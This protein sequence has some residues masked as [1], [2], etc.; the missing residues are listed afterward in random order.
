MKSRETGSLFGKTIGGTRI[1]P[2]AFKIIVVF[3]LFIL[4]SNLTSNYVNLVFNRTKMVN[5]M[6]QLLAKDL[7]DIYVY[8]N[9]QFEIYNYNKD[10]KGSLSSIEN[11]ALNEFSKRKS[12]LLGV[13]PDGTILFQA[14]H[15]ARSEKFEDKGTLAELDRALAKNTGEG[16]IQFN[17]NGE[18]YFGIYKHNPKWEVFIIRAEEQNEFYEESR[19]VF[20]DVSV[21]ILVIT[22]ICGVAGVYVLR[23]VLRFIGII[24]SEI[25][26]M[27]DEQQLR[28]INLK[29]APNDDITFLGVA[30][31]SLASTISNLLNIF[32]KFANRDVVIKAY[33]EREVRLEGRQSE[34]VILFSDIKS[35]T[36]ITETLGADI[37]KLLNLHYDQA[38]R[39]V[40][41]RDGIIGS[42]I[43][44]ALLAV[45]GA[46]DQYEG[47]HKNKSYQSVIT[48]YLLQDLAKKLRADM[49]AKK[50]DIEKNKGSLNEDQERVYQAVLLEIGVGIDGGLVFY[51]NIGSHIRMTNTVIGDNVN[52]ASRLEG[53][54]REYKLP[55]ICSEYIKEDIEESEHAGEIKFF[56]IDVVKVKGKTE[57]K[58]IYWPV[59]KKDY[60]KALEKSMKAFSAGLELYYK[61]DW[62]KANQLFKRC[63]LPV[64]GIFAARTSDL[65][66]PR[67]WNGIW[68]MKTK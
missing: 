44:D 33:R 46:L 21:I 58:K 48:A 66:P 57:G 50:K 56:E 52:A 62:R 39:R 59:L 35:F 68:E 13:K 24:T 64:G 67:N 11:K 45:F 22:I 60:T 54:T 16:I 15:F 9:N 41:E 25:M 26:T 49:T 20:R 6:R 31:N 10:M 5:M 34:L 28:I 7:K 51:G 14:S 2:V 65:T 4:V 37:I 12:V 55:V 32:R 19:A 8:C 42:I 17:F 61:G 29:G 43:G 30:F 3:A 53:L 18:A 40:V 63:D 38:I 23:Y 47:E 36:F 1:V 27:L